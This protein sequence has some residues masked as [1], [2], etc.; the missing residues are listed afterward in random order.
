[1]AAV[2]EQTIEQAI[3]AERLGFD[4]VWTTEHHFVADG[5]SQSLLPS[6]VSPRLPTLAGRR[7]RQGLL[8]VKPSLR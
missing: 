6:Q 7:Y 4:H 3:Y 2:Y 1:M 8:L 5:Y